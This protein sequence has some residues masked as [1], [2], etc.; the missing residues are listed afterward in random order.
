MTALLALTGLSKS[1]ARV[2]ALRDVSLVVARGE[3]LALVG[4]SG[5]GKSTLARIILRLERP[6]AGTLALDGAV[7]STR[8]AA[9]LAYRKRVQMIFQDPFGSLNPV[10]PILHQLARPLLRHGLATKADVRLSALALLAEVG[11]EPASD[12]IDQH[13]HALSGGQRQ[14]V[15]IARALAPGPELL[16]ADEPT[17]MLDVSL[18]MGILNLLAQ[19]KRQGLSVILITHDLASARYLADRI[20][21][22]YRGEVME[23]AP[24][25]ALVT[26]PGHPYTRLLLSVARGG[27]RSEGTR[28]PSQEAASQ[29]GCPFAARCPEVLSRC[30][31]EAPPW[32]ALATDHHVRCHR[33]GAAGALGP[34]DQSS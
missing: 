1:Y 11:L 33:A 20:V 24:A 27:A 8:R 10:H 5:C 31:V 28:A 26:A 32:V 30:R 23:E 18:R 16:V 9:S 19:K 14:R 3:A 22:L 29:V 4:E 34:E 6:D 15:A 12:Y 25:D 17:S 13:P 7:V 21:V 2:Q